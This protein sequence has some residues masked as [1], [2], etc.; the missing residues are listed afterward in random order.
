MHV[1]EWLDI[2]NVSSFERSKNTQRQRAGHCI[3][4]DYESP[5]ATLKTGN[6]GQ[7]IS[8]S[9]HSLSNSFQF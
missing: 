4:L 1:K 2:K 5:S 6:E 7:K 3:I 8:I 9:G